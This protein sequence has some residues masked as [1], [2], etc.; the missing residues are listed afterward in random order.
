MQKY[1]PADRAGQTISSMCNMFHT[2]A[3][4]SCSILFPSVMPHPSSKPQPISG[5]GERRVQPFLDVPIPLAGSCGSLLAPCRIHIYHSMALPGL[6]CHAF[7][8]NPGKPISERQ[9]CLEKGG[10]KGR[11]KRE[12]PMQCQVLP[13]PKAGLA[14]SAS[15]AASATAYAVDA[16]ALSFTDCSGLAFKLL[17]L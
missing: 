7:R 5:A 4:D 11:Q 15:S 14:A 13:H 8:A 12:M 10:A 6:G 1:S 16:P 3:S 9:P 2:L 17:H